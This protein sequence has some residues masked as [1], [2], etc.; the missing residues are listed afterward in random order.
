METPFFKFPRVV[1]IIGLKVN[2]QWHSFK[3][4]FIRTGTAISI[5]LDT[6]AR[7]L[8]SLNAR[9]QPPEDLNRVDAIF[10]K[11]KN[12]LGQTGGDYRCKLTIDLADTDDISVVYK[13]IIPQD[14]DACKMA[15][16]FAVEFINSPAKRDADPAIAL[17]AVAVMKDRAGGTGLPRA[18]SVIAK[19]RKKRSG[20]HDHDEP[21]FNKGH[22]IRLHHNLL[23][24]LVA[25]GLYWYTNQNQTL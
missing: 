25:R 16:T 11:L 20:H 1:I 7:D 23:L 12:L 2:I 24:F 18:E 10:T 15:A 19:Q 13:P 5:R 17:L 22:R 6:A 9:V 14:E 4:S 8:I 3:T 21:F